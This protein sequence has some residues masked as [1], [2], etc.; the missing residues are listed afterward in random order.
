MK[1]TKKLVPMTVFDKHQLKISRQT[2][3]YSDVGAK[4]MGGQ[5]K[6]EARAFI[7]KM[8]KAGKIR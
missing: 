4:I 8:K 7:V 6:S 3:R 1:K 2:L 5:T